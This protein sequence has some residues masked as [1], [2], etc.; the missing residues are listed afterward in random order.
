M[1]QF[2][3]KTIEEYQLILIKNPR[4]PVFAAL[5]EAYRKM[6]LIEEALEV[7]TK[8]VK[9]NPEFVSGLVAHAKILLEMKDYSESLQVLKKAHSLKPENLLALKLLSHV[10][11]KLK[12][13][14]KALLTYKK[15]L[16][17]NP[18]DNEAIQFIAK[19]Q[20]LESSEKQ[21]FVTP[22]EESLDDWVEQLPSVDHALHIIDSF[23]NANDTESA[24]TILR[25]ALRVW[26]DQPD[27]KRRLALLKGLTPEAM[28]R[29]ESLAMKK[30]V[31]EIKK[32]FFQNW[33]QR[34]EQIKG[35]DPT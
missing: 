10:Y 14:Q 13:Y 35:V 2:D 18:N 34:V 23:L 6:G 20:F 16:I 4:S 15:L 25:P 17:F 24:E 33:L 26:R 5:A 22:T 32:I 11:I 31:I 19:W 3:P 12:K 8:G 9:H 29:S 27:L 7:T 28:E 30:K 21:K 1:S